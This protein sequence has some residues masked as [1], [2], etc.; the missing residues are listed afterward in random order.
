MN[1]II[2]YL[3]KVFQSICC[4]TAQ[5]CVIFCSIASVWTFNSSNRE[6]AV[7]V[8]R[9]CSSYL[10]IKCKMTPVRTRLLKSKNGVSGSETENGDSNDDY[11]SE[12]QN[13]TEIIPFTEFATLLDDMNEHLVRNNDRRTGD[14]QRNS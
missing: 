10:D 12:L 9:S 6:C 14:E 13:T 8:F 3:L 4:N 7:F 11:D 2:I 5:D 1:T